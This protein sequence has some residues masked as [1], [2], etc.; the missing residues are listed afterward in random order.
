MALGCRSKIDV[1]VG[2]VLRGDLSECSA[3]FRWVFDP[4]PTRA[5]PALDPDQLAL[6]LLRFVRFAVK[7][8]NLQYAECG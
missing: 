8:T 1:V 3:A 7:P 4:G 2:V 6:D 5:C